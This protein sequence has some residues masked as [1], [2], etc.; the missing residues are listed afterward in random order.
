MSKQINRRATLMSI[1]SAQGG[2]FFSIRTD[3]GMLVHNGRTGVRQGRMVKKVYNNR[4]LGLVSSYDVKRLVHE[5][6]RLDTTYE[7]RAG[8]NRYLIDLT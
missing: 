8:G 4:S 5:H 3:T 2:K 1:I 7:L 6:I